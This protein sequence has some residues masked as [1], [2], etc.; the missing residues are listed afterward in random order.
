[1][2]KTY[3]QLLPYMEKSYALSTALTLLSWDEETLAPKE[4]MQYTSKA[5]GTLSTE[6]F[7]TLM[8]P[9]LKK[10]LKKLSEEK[11]QET[12]SELEKA[13]VKNMKKSFD[14]LE[15]IPPEDYRAYSEL[16]A[17]ASSIWAAA[18][19]KSCF[20]DFAPTLKEILDY[21]KQFAKLRA[22]DGQ[23]PY[24]A[25]LNM[26]EE[27]FTMEKLDEFFD[28]IRTAVVPLLKKVVAKN[29]RIDKSYN[30]LHY[31]IDKQ[32]EFCRYI[33]G[34]EG[35]DFNRGVIAESAH[36][37]TTNLHNH[38]VRIT[39]HF[40]EDNLESAIFS[41]I[42]EAGHA[43]Y[44]MN[45][46]DELTLTPAGGGTSMGM[47]ESQSRFFENVIGRS[48]DFW[49]PV[50]GRLQETFPEQLS[51]VPL[52]RFIQGINKAE[53]G[54][55]RTEADELTYPLHIMIRYE[56]ERMLFADEIT[57]EDLPK[58]WNQKYKDYLGIEPPNDAQGVLQDVHWSG[59][60][61]GYFPSYAI[62]SAIAA[63]IYAYMKKTM[64]FEEYLREGNLTPIR[65]FLRLHIHQYGSS[66]NTSEL[67]Q[68]MMNEDLNA[69]YYVDYLTEKYTGLYELE[70]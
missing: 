64:P 53:P 11:E 8:N 67:L 51:D 3:E 39:N 66:K 4:G 22:K 35:F 52:S 34:Y 42:H 1:M 20:A 49:L 19:E 16:V 58:I 10:L 30:Y 68:G 12:L 48:A 31:D 14:E 44:E 37:F 9:E 46:N 29:D 65:E 13:V 57:V 59:G 17:K 55:I 50:Y 32:R 45:V 18:K 69:D 43:M 33:A 27:G 54:L 56:I 60:S 36:P 6:L 28:K 63:Q 25:M 41:I 47:H 21:N 2:N 62:G 26:Y 24:D 38:D 40:H 23:A 15:P 7:S 61:F 70:A 5:I